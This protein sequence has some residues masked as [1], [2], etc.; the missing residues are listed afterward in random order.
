MVR[1]NADE[2]AKNLLELI[3]K[4]DLKIDYVAYK[5]GVCRS[6][7]YHWINGRSVPS[8]DCLIILADMFN[9]KIDDLIIVDR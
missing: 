7:V 8:I 1:F 3:T 2:T 4:N 6:A 5:C 9:C